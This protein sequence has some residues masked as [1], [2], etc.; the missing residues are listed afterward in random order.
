[1]AFWAE[2]RGAAG[3]GFFNDYRRAIIAGLALSAVNLQLKLKVTAFATLV[4]KVTNGGAA[5]FNGF[6]QN[7]AAAFNDPAPLPDRKAA[8]LFGRFQTGMKQDFAGIDVAD[9]DNYVVVH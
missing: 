9:S 8:H 2:K 4:N 1:M 5:A 7:I 6:L 3:H